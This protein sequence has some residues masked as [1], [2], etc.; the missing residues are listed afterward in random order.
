MLFPFS[1][2]YTITSKQESGL[3]LS[4]LVI[5]NVTLKDNG[6]YKCLATNAL[7]NGDMP[8]EPVLI[9]QGKNGMLN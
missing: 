9:V 1:C 2:S 8:G 4:D 3:H 7:G 5:E 6:T